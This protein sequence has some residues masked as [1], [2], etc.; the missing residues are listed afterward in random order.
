MSGQKPRQ[1]NRGRQKNRSQNAG[2]RS[3]MSHVN[4]LASRAQLN[5]PLPL[6]L[7]SSR[8]PWQFGIS[9]Y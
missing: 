2:D 5:Q 3:H 8:H 1:M 7:M 4:H 9:L 6:R